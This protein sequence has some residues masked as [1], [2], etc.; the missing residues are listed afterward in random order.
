MIHSNSFN[1]TPGETELAPG[2]LELLARI[3][4]Q[5]TELAAEGGTRMRGELATELVAEMG[6][7]TELMQTGTISS[8]EAFSG[9]SATQQATI[10]AATTKAKLMVDN[11]LNLILRQQGQTDWTGWFGLTN[12]LW[13][14]DVTL[15]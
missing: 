10:T 11:A 6:D 1:L 12:P 13:E 8:P 15:G 14:A 2:E 9:C 4:T 7:R 5:A 3:A